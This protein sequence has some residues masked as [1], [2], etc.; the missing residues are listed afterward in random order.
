M[1]GGSLSRLSLL[2]KILIQGIALSLSGSHGLDI[3]G[4]LVAVLFHVPTIS[5]GMILPPGLC[6]PV[7]G[8]LVSNE[9][10][11]ITQG[12]GATSLSFIPKGLPTVDTDVLGKH[13]FLHSGMIW[14]ES[15]K[16]A[17]ATP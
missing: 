10:A 16:Q 4:M 6:G 8:C 5:F 3:L 12:S 9:T 11:G 2:P 13:V 1:K 17:R 7:V 14:L 15:D